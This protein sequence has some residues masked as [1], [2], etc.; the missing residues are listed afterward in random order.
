MSYKSFA[1]AAVLL[2]PYT[3]AADLETGRPTAAMAQFFTDSFH[4]RTSKPL[5]IVIGDV[6]NAGLIALGS[7]DRPSLFLIDAPERTPWVTDED[8]RRKGAVVV[9]PSLDTGGA[10]PPA[11]RARFPD[12]IAEVPRSFERP[13]Q[14]RL[15]LLRLGWAV[16]RPSAET[17]APAPR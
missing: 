16:I 12:L 5:A 14:G 7:P 8:I 3:V 6:G 4:R 9:W 11:I 1:T 15:P 2:A 10:P 13:L 17:A